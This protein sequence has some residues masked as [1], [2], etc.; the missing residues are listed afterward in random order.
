MSNLSQCHFH[1][2]SRRIAHEDEQSLF[3]MLCELKEKFPNTERNSRNHSMFFNHQLA[4]C[5]MKEVMILLIS[6]IDVLEKKI[7]DYEKQ[8]LPVAELVEYE[9]VKYE[10]LF[11]ILNPTK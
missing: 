10:P 5:E 6:R 11:P 1:L 8:E 7:S 2:L 9:P 4:L 3:K